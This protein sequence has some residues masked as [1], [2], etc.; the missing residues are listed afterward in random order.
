M[1]VKCALPTVKLQPFRIPSAW[2]VDYNTFIE[3]D[4]KI[5]DEADS[6]WMHFTEDLLQISHSRYPILVDVGWYPEGNSHG[7]YGLEVI[8]DHDWSNPL[9]SF[10]T[11]DKD[12]MVA[13]IEQLLQIIGAGYYSR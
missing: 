8:K 2:K 6:K 10:S 12:E 1:R 4:P 9:E 11:N 3:L 7:E 13:K 5:L